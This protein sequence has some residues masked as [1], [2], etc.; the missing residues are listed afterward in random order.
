MVMLE[1]KHI[2]VIYVVFYFILRDVV[3]GD[4]S[5]GEQRSGFTLMSFSDTRVI[6]VQCNSKHLPEDIKRVLSI[7]LKLHVSTSESLHVGSLYPYGKLTVLI[8]K[9]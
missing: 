9:Q 2:H 6:S 5:K 3:I 8:I 1:N 4:D 7:N